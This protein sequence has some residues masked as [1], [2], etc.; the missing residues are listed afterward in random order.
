MGNQ[1]TKTTAKISYYG[2]VKETESDQSVPLDLFFEDIRRGKWEDIVHA[3]RVISDKKQRDDLKKKTIPIVTISGTFTKRNDQG[4]KDKSGFI[5]IDIDNVDDPHELKSLVCP[6]KYV[7]AAF[8]SVSGRGLCV[9]FN[10][11]PEKHRESFNGISEYLFEHYNIVC[12]PTSVNPSRA[13]FVSWDADMYISSNYDKFT[14]YPKEKQKEKFDK[15][16]YAEDDFQNILKQ[17]KERNIDITDSSYPRWLK[18]AFAL[19]HQFGE[20][21]RDYF[22]LVSSFS[23]K[24]NPTVTDK[25]YDACLKHKGG[26]IAAIATFYYYCKDKGVD[27]YSPKTKLVAHS[28]RHGKKGGLNA[29]QVVENLKNFE[30]IDTTVDEVQDIMNANV[31]LDDEDSLLAQLE[32]WLRQNYDL[33]LNEV[34]LYIENKGRS[35]ESR[36]LNSIYIKAKKI[37]DKLNYELV[38]RLIHS[39]FTPPY[40][41]FKEFFDKYKE[42]YNPERVAGTIEKFWSC[43]ES[44]AE[45]EH[46]N[47]FCTKWLV[48]IV[49]SIYGAHSVLMPVLSGAKQNTGKTQ[50]FRRL[51]PKELYDERAPKGTPRYYAESK[52]D[53]G[54]DDLILMTQR[55]IV[56][57]DE[58][59]GKSKKENKM[60]KDI[61]SK[62][63]FTLREP[64]GRYNVD[65][66]R[67]A[68]L[69]GTTNDNEI[70]SDFS[71]NR[72]II[73]IN[74]LSIDYATMN[75]IDRIALLME[76]YWLFH[77]ETYSHELTAADITKLEGDTINFEVTDLETE[78]VQKYFQPGKE[79][80][81][82]ASEIKI[83]LQTVTGDR[84]LLDRVGKALKRLGF[85]QE[86]VRL[87]GGST[88][89]A[90]LVTKI[91]QSRPAGSS[92]L[93]D[94]DCPF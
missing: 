13:R 38:D 6:D 87:A 37:F 49:S 40:N 72:R 86:H 57:D 43:I 4:I 30:Q 34:T 50:V 17:I 74:V 80:K 16:V 32:I 18:I 81:L 65:L 63:I 19:V 88:K 67:L 61:T 66:V 29:A 25:Q 85:Q 69:A 8:T 47:Y 20:T 56:M 84:F 76:A 31:D 71:G 46:V 92:E 5:A 33:R 73:P 35:V 68:S 14:R 15:V 9:V 94:E 36:D 52:L 11:N 59:A 42:Q 23:S 26:K 75:K 41:P 54:K 10:I 24:Y 58:M 21:G 53:A 51:L 93:K 22:Q 44:S 89:R 64:Y 45:P 55:L 70:L 78:M 82:S 39:D 90:W 60:L 79:E 7:V 62:Q 77:D 2:S 83:H 12:D 27:L 91:D 48:G 28:A 1:A 3:V